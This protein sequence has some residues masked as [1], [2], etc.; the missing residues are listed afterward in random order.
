MIKSPTGIVTVTG[1]VRTPG[2][3]AR[4]RIWR[5]VLNEAGLKLGDNA[6]ERLS[7]R[8]S[9]PPAGAANAARAAMLSGGGEAAV[10]EAM[11]G[12]LQ[13]LGIGPNSPDDD[14][15]DFDPALVNCDGDLAGLTERLVRLSLATM[16]AMPLRAAWHRQVPIRPLP[17]SATRHGGNAAAGERPPV[18]VG[19]R[20]READCRRLPDGPRTPRHAGYRRSGLAA[21][22]PARGLR[23]WEVTQVNEM[24][25]WM[26]S[27][28]LPFVCTTNLMDRIDQASLR[29]FT[30]KLRFAP[31]SPAQTRS[32][33]NASSAS[34]QRDD[35]QTT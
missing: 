4:M 17:R 2:R 21:V 8:Y 13:L 14:A 20:K 7:S 5:R 28:P 34:S 22:R 29:R 16:V 18:D 15:S 11:G 12:V 31:L 10:E 26:E 25:T 3:P 32:L 30:L 35:S 27:H 1:E 33:L 9:A 24:L 6:I 23:S 19:R